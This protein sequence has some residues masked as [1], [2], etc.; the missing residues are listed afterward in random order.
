V[1]DLQKFKLFKSTEMLKTRIFIYMTLLSLSSQAQTDSLKTEDELSDCTVM[2]YQQMTDTTSNSGSGTLISIRDQYYILTASHVAQL[3]KDNSKIIFRLS[4][5]KPGIFNLADLTQNHILNWKIHPIADLALLHVYPSNEQLKAIF[6]KSFFPAYSIAAGQQLP[7]R[8]F[9]FT[10]FGYP[11]I[12][13]KLEHFS[14][15]VFDSRLASGLITNSRYDNGQKCTFYY[16][17]TPSMQG[18]SGS[19]V[20]VS[21]KKAMFF[22]GHQTFMVGIVHGTAKDDTGGKLAAITPLF[23]LNDLQLD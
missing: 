4:G 10:F 7:S 1:E 9:E 3:L 23:Y 13:L 17:N 6:S 8:D 11:I 14:P 12:D 19:G 16:L 15:L 21:V 22:G 18:C 5:D 20:Y 2:L